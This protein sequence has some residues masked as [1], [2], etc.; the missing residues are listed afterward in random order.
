MQGVARPYSTQEDT[1]D[2]RCVYP[3]GHDDGNFPTKL[4]AKGLRR[5]I[6]V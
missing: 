5:S 3:Q 1:E 4:A 6:R 2:K